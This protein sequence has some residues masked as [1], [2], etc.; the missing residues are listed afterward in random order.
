MGER[1]PCERV[2]VFWKKIGSKRRGPLSSWT[3]YYF[4]AYNT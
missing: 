3:I 2:F 1:E 4:V